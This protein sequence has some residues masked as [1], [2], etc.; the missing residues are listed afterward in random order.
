M[1]PPPSADNKT[2]DSVGAIREGMQIDGAKLTAYLTT[3][4]P[5][6]KGPLQIKQFKLG[7]SN[8]TY[9]LTDGNNKRYVLRKKPPGQLISTKAHAVER[10]YQ[11]INALGT[12]TD[13][14][15]PIVYTLCTDNSIVGT[16]FYV[17]EFLDGRIFTDNNLTGVELADKKAYYKSTM[18][19][20]SK[21]HTTASPAALNL[22]SFGKHGDFYA[23]QIAT[24]VAISKQQASVVDENGTRGLVPEIPRLNEMIS[25]FQRNQVP[26]EVS[27]IHGDFKVDNMVFHSVAPRVIG[28]LDWELSTIG[29]PLSDL[30]NLLL[31]WYTPAVV[32]ANAPG[33]IGYLDAPRPLPVP[34]AEDLIKEYCRR[35]GRP[36]PIPKFDF[37]IAF[38]FFRLTVISQGIA[39]R[40][41]RKQASSA[42]AT[43][44]VKMMIP[45]ANLVLGFVDKGDLAPA[46]I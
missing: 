2:T 9:F 13:V 15:V 5:N 16:P 44:A 26:D 21:L 30:A 18:D 33:G 37:C 11:V 34:E 29:H 36:Y 24:L 19:T 23:R 20:L 42:S 41:V 3:A 45:C 22:S 1:P 43:M 39:S 6:F 8:P 7:Q 10:E 28:V 17:M 31:P 40:V 38:S 32:G 14:P 27:V 46:K 35:A 25:W 12:K 4:V